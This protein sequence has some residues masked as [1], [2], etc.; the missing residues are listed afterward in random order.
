[1]RVAYRL[2]CFVLGALLTSVA[3]SGQGVPQDHQGQYSAADIEA[4]SRLYAAQCAL[5]HGPNGDAVAGVDL[6]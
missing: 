1:M 5:C 3:M 2:A 6:R 4:G